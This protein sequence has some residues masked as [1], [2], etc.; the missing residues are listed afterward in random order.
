MIE[1]IFKTWQLVLNQVVT[2]LFLLSRPFLDS[3]KMQKQIA[4]P[5][6]FWNVALEVWVKMYWFHEDVKQSKKN[7]PKKEIKTYGDL[8]TLSRSGRWS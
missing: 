7:K 3:I 5:Q 4:F 8:L 2:Y 1:N 6:S